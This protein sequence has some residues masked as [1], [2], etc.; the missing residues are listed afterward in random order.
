V[1]F[2]RSLC[3]EIFDAEG[4]ESVDGLLPG[5]PDMEGV[6]N[7]AAAPI[8]GGEFA[9]DFLIVGRLQ[10]DDAEMGQQ[11]IFED[12]ERLGGMNARVS[13]ALVRIA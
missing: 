8:R 2:F 6:V 4:V 5:A 10:G 3:L 13:G 12:A 7:L 1:N 11:I 9:N